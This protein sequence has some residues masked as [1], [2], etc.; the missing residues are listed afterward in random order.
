MIDL[1]ALLHS[2][3]HPTPRPLVYVEPTILWSVQW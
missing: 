2:L 1:A 3:C